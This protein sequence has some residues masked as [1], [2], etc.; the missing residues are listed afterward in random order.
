MNWKIFCKKF[1]RIVRKFIALL[2]S[3]ALS[4]KLRK[5]W[6]TYKIFYKIKFIHFVRNYRYK[7]WS[8]LGRGG[9][10]NW[11][12]P[13]AQIVA[14]WKTGY[15]GKRGVT[16]PVSAT[17]GPF[18]RQ[19]G[20]KLPLFS[21][22]ITYSFSRTN[23]ELTRNISLILSSQAHKFLP[24]YWKSSH[25][26]EKLDGFLNWWILKLFLFDERDLRIYFKNQDANRM[27]L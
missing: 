18:V 25:F 15:L 23:F 6:I 11:V 21:R 19:T 27:S 26:G 8:G 17:W 1:Q 5:T 10:S 2:C 14:F 12:C 9:C 22:V 4:V 7:V 16:Q 13:S 3:K 20:C 24:P